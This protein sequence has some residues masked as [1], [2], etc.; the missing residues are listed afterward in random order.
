MYKWR[1]IMENWDG[2]KIDKFFHNKSAAINFFN[3]NYQNSLY[4]QILRYN[5][6][7]WI[8]KRFYF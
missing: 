5:G 6:K 1:V 8:I 4:A 3:I 2:Q 7:I